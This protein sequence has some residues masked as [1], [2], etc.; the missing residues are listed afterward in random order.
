MT[1]TTLIQP[2]P[3]TRAEQAEAAAIERASK[4]TAA[5]AVKMQLR[6]Q[7]HR[8]RADRM[9]A[10]ARELLRTYK[11]TGYIH[12]SLSVEAG[13][14]LNASGRMMDAYQHGLLTLAK[15]R[16]GGQQ[17][18]VVQHVNVGDGGQAMVAGEVKLREKGRAKR[19]AKVAGEGEK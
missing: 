17:T 9:Q 3:P 6:A 10:E 19:Q 1:E 7:E 5:D 15:I 14:M 12:Q 18:V 2:E 8:H 16:S 13:R 11:R 4:L